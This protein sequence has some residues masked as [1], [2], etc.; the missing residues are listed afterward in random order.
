MI[1]HS[2]TYESI[3]YFGLYV[4]SEHDISLHISLVVRTRLAGDEA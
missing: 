3:A 2:A 4:I 1:K